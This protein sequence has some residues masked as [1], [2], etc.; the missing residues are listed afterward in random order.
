MRVHVH[1]FELRALVFDLLSGHDFQL[2]SQFL[3]ALAPVSFDDADH[4]VLAA[5]V[6]RIASLN[7][8]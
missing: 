4:H 2:D 3:D 6:R 8:L 7:M 1:L 5:A